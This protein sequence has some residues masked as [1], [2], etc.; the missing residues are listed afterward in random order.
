MQDQD[1]LP[2]E[3]GLGRNA[4][5]PP[6]LKQEEKH[7]EPEGHPSD[8]PAER[9][10]RSLNMLRQSAQG[11]DWMDVLTMN[12]QH[13]QSSGYMKTIARAREVSSA[14]KKKGLPSR[15]T[16]SPVFVGRTGINPAIFLFR[17]GRP[18]RDL[19][20]GSRYEPLRKPAS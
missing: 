9:Q 11:H 2:C 7:Q 12:I 10:V 19:I 8:D 3:I 1:I 6:D 15:V 20:L 13:F 18:Q 5:G 4:A 14:P 17:H 16:P